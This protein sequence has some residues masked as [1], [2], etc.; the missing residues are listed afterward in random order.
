MDNNIDGNVM[1]FDAVRARTLASLDDLREQFASGKVVAVSV[2]VVTDDGFWSTKHVDTND[3]VYRLI[4]S[5]EVTK[6]VLLGNLF[7]ET[8]LDDGP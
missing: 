6:A 3:D 8:T 5:L 2:S 4:G 1:Q 7:G